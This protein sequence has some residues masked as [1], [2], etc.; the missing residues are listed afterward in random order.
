M[1]PRG[2]LR[3][4]LYS[5]LARRDVVAARDY[6]ATRGYQP[7][8]RDIRSARQALRTSPFGSVERF[9]DFFCVSECRDL[10]FHVQEHRFTIAQIRQLLADHRLTFIGFELIE[11]V[12][13][14]YRYPYQGDPAMQQLDNW[15]TFEAE[16]PDTFT[17]MYE[18]WVQTP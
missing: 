13:A 11:A 14:A 16:R 8:T 7:T 18:F 10:L 15:E 6:C 9:T 2:F 12:R 4:G 1:R 5:E 3:I 17:N